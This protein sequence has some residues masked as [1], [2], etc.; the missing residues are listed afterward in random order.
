MSVADASLPPREPGPRSLTELESRIARDLE[1]LIIPP[2]KDWVQPTTHP[3]WGPLLDVAIIG[4]G[5]SALA[6]AFALK[7]LGVRNVRLFDRSPAGFEGPWATYARME[8]LRSPPELTGPALGMANFTF[9]A[10]FEAQF[11]LGP[12][13]ELYR[14]PRLQWMDYLRWLRRVTGAVVENDTEMTALTGDGTA[15]RLSLASGGRTR[16]VGARCMVLAT[17]RDGLGGPFIPQFIRNLDKRGW[18]HSS[19]AIDFAALKGKTV[20]VI[21]AG[22]SA[23][24]NAAEAL[25]AGAARVAMLVRRA[26]MPR[27]NRGMGI[28]SPGMWAGYHRLSLPQRLS[29]VQ[30]IEENG[31]PPPHGSMLRCSRHKNFSL[32]TNCAPASARLSGDKVLLD[33][34]RG[35]LAFDFVIV[36]TGFNVDWSKRPE[37]SAIAAHVLKWKDRFTP[38]KGRPFAQAEDPFL[39]PDLQF[40]EKTPGEA[41]WLGRIH[42]FTFPAYT[43]HGAISGDIPGVSAGAER[44][45]DGIAASLFAED[46]ERNFARLLAYNTPELTGDEFSVAENADDFLAT[47]ESAG[48]DGA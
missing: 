14:I 28:G 27:F 23:V 12:W 48:K 7:R 39:G 5:M 32:I 2:A 26:E 46:Y 47:G 37:L 17:G 3:Q 20:A 36:A 16:E 21:G 30:H 41:P 19:E 40:L 6:T 1:L 22:A 15:L 4:A 25:E 43:S 9:R 24:D 33:T 18:A 8:T 44:V 38:T 35:L 11:G 13:R 34:N 42:C 10:W 31:I 45:A 29:I